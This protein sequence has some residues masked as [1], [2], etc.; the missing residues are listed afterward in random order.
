MVERPQRGCPL[1][2][3]EEFTKRLARDVAALESETFSNEYLTQ[4]TRPCVYM[5]IKDGKPLY[6]GKGA[7]GLMRAAEPKHQ[8]AKV[9]A[10]ADEIRVLWCKKESH[11]RDLERRLIAEHNPPFNGAPIERQKAAAR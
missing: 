9:R 4:I 10:I 7:H 1:T 6:I 8:R 3:D 5:F 2:R 11:A